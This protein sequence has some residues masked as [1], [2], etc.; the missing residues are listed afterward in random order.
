MKRRLSPKQK[1]WLVGV[2]L[3]V[4]VGCLAATMVYVRPAFIERGE[5]WTY[6]IRAR[7]AAATTL[8]RQDIL[9][10]HVDELDIDSVERNTNLSWPWP[11]ALFGYITTYAQRAGAKA[12]VFDFVFQDRGR[13]SVD[14]ASE[15]AN[16]LRASNHSVIGLALTKELLVDELPT[17]PWAALLRRVANLDEAHTVAMLLQSWNV[18]AF[19]IPD[20]NQVAVW[21]GGFATRDEVVETWQRLQTSDTAG[22]LMINAPTDAPANT[23]PTDTAPVDPPADAAPVEPTMRQLTA[24]ELAGEFQINEVISAKYGFV[25]NQQSAKISQSNG[26]D[27]PLGVLA[28]APTRLGH[29]HQAN[30]IDGVIRHHK[31]LV[32]YQDRWF[33]SLPLAAYLVTHPTEQ[34]SM[35]GDT[36]HLGNKRIVLDDNG[37]AAIRWTRPD[38]TASIGAYE[39]LRSQALLDEGKPPSISN[40]V[41]KDKYVIISAVA[42]S[43][44]DLRA[45]P[46]DKSHLGAAINAN[47]IDNL[48]S[49]RFIVR[50]SDTRDALITFACCVLLTMLIGLLWL[51]VRNVGFMLGAVTLL[52]AVALWSYWRLATWLLVETDL[53][54]SLAVPFVAMVV[55]AF[56]TLLTLSAQERNSRR[57]ATEALGRYTSKA[58]VQE[59]LDHPEHLSLEWGRR[60][61]MSV[62]FSDIAGFT[63]I[64]EGLTPERLVALLNDYLTHMTDIVLAHGGVIDKYIGDAVMAFWGAPVDDPLHA[65]HA[66]AC[67][68]A[69]RKRCDELRPVW[70]A[71][72]GYE[73]FARAGVNSGNAVVGNMGSKHKYNYTVMG[74]MVNLAS[75]LEGANKAY[76]TYLMISESTKAIVEH[77]FDL[78]ELDL[79]AVKG[80]EQPVRVFEVIDVKG[81]APAAA[82]A[83][84]TAF[85]TALTLYRNREFAQAKEAFAALAEHDPT[86]KV[87]VDRCLHFLEQ[88]PK[89]SSDGTWDG[90]WH[91]TEK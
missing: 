16:A 64:S 5:L 67:A 61:P 91:M 40:D 90:V 7:R 41:F 26:M 74:D 3:G 42:H 80:K 77:Q 66:V 75:R 18:R 24:P 53:W 49:G 59:L 33:P 35:H 45:S 88:P 20:G 10:V 36:L 57:F 82:L 58:L 76:G 48:E 32:R 17:G 31:L 62:Y 86:A 63:T 29:V 81:H 87:Y 12:V 44:R 38:R 60:R 68:L 65:Q 84:A 51:A 73:I 54:I 37:A 69:M 79:V 27:P 55:T 22:Q 89:L 78:R 21:Y 9:M 11:R 8:P 23:A 30:D 50:I 34:V 14:D 83:N 72:F 70:K 4:I 43:L 47:V 28:T 25:A 6:D 85:V 56:S 71:R 39:I 13:D 46:V 2:V 52:L 15:F 1:A 19:L